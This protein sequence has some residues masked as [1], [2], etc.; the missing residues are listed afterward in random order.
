MPTAHAQPIAATFATITDNADRRTLTR[1]LVLASLPAWLAGCKTAPTAS[2][3]PPPRG[4][5]SAPVPIPPSVSTRAALAAEHQRL[6]DLFRGT[7]V[8]VSLQADGSLR[9]EVP[10]TYC[11]DAGRAVVKPPLAAVLDRVAR[12][13]RHE[14]TRVRVAA[15]GDAGGRAPQLAKERGVSIREFMMARG[16]A[17]TRFAAPATSASETI[18]VVVSD[19]SGA[20]GSSGAVKP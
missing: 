8:L 14:L 7:P 17:F 18:E 1:R 20:A 11:F 9:I 5:S 12:D 4:S 10:L 6:A 16:V 15:P 2:S 3:A 19:A 13:Q